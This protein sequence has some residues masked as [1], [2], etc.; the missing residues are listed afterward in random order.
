MG[1]IT[2]RHCQSSWRAVIDKKQLSN[3]SAKG[4]LIFLKC[5]KKDDAFT[6]CPLLEQIEGIAFGN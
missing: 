4:T 2:A 3:S 6:Y 5:R 1:L